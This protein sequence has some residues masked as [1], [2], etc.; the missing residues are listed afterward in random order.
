MQCVFR[1]DAASARK[2]LSY[3][4]EARQSSILTLFAD[5][6]SH[7]VDLSPW[8]ENAKRIVRGSK[9]TATSRPLATTKRNVGGN[10][11]ALRRLLQAL[12][13]LLQALPRLLQALPRLLHVGIDPSAR[14]VDDAHAAAAL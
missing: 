12:P 5:E 14:I 7:V 9:V 2:C 4:I 1:L 11:Q 13:W 6:R 8:I 10:F 3:H